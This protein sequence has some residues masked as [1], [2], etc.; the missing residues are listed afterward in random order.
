MRARIAPNLLTRLRPRFP[1]QMKISPSREPVKCWIAHHFPKNAG[2]SRSSCWSEGKAFPCIL[3]VIVF[4]SPQTITTWGQSLMCPMRGL[5]WEHP[6][7]L[8]T[9]VSLFVDDNVDAPMILSLVA[10]SQCLQS[11]GATNVLRGWW[12]NLELRL[13]HLEG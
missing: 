5:F 10:A 9:S 4:P 8:G 11:F 6:K 12:G 13:P 7:M 1:C 2:F 3:L